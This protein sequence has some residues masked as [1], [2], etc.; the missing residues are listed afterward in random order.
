MSRRSIGRE[1]NDRADAGR[2]IVERSALIGSRRWERRGARQPARAI[3]I[4]GQSVECALHTEGEPARERAPERGGVGERRASLMPG[5]GAQR[6]IDPAQY[7]LSEG[8]H[9]RR[10]GTG[11]SRPVVG[12]PSLEATERCVELE[13]VRRAPGAVSMTQG[14]ED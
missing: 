1:E 8:R 9:V 10:D 6:G 13:I 12:D 7:A 4:V 14:T 5:D 2:A 11:G 3:A